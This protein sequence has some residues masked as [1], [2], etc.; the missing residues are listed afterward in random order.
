MVYFMLCVIHHNLKK[1]TVPVDAAGS[2]EKIRQGVV[3]ERDGDG[4]RGEWV[5]GEALS[6]VR[7]WGESIPRR[8]TQMRGD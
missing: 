1:K 7:I 4:T 8:G 5:I 2:V 3:R 6:L